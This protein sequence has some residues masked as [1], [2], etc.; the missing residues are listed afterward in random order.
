MNELSCPHVKMFTLRFC[1]VSWYVFRAI[2]MFIPSHYYRWFYAVYLYLSY[3]QVN[4]SNN[5][6]TRSPPASSLQS[7]VTFS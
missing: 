3:F 7:V 1:L 2:S 4:H 5:N 6:K